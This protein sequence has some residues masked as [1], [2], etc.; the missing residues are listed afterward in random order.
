MVIGAVV[1]IALN[2]TYNSQEIKG[3]II[4]I[5]KHT[6]FLKNTIVFMT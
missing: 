2:H 6:A 3:K 1:S 5:L 4:P